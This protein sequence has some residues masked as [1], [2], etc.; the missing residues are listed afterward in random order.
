MQFRNQL[1]SKDSKIDQLQKSLNLNSGVERLR[2]ECKKLYESENEAMSAKMDDIVARA[3]EPNHSDNQLE[4]VMALES[5]SKRNFALNSLPNP[6]S[7]R[8]K[9][10]RHKLQEAIGPAG[11]ARRSHSSLLFGDTDST[12]LPIDYRASVSTLPPIK[13]GRSMSLTSQISESESLARVLSGRRISTKRKSEETPVQPDTMAETVPAV[14]GA[15]AK[16][17]QESYA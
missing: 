10:F 17:D 6:V 15:T 13:A 2:D 4:S 14:V 1:Q 7:T 5:S 9:V 11:S 16:R 3:R 12:I 8:S